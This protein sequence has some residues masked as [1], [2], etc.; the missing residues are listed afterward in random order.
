MIFDVDHPEWLVLLVFAALPMITRGYRLQPYPALGQELADPLSRLLELGLRFA[1]SFAIAALV[2]GLAGL[3]L[4]GGSIER[5]GEGAHIVILVDRSA[6]MDNSFAG[7]PPSGEEE[8]KSA[9]ARRL[10]SAFVETRQHDHFGIAAFSTSPIHVLPLTAEKDAVLAAI[11][12]ID[13]PGLAFTDV[14]RGLAMAVGMHNADT[15]PAPRAILLVSDGA[16]VIDRKVQDQLRKA[17][18]RQP[19]NLYWL[20]LRTQGSKGI[21]YQP[22]PDEV[23]SPERL[24]E[25]HLHK[26]FQTLGVPYRAFQAENPQAIADA[27]REI[28]KLE[29]RLIRYTEEIQQTDLSALAYLLASVALLALVAAKMLEAPALVADRSSV[30]ALH[31]SEGRQS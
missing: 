31:W 14:G 23:D 27:I 18:A 28:D 10:L 17:L 7:R 19:V 8:S 26:L 12:A 25:R 13:R 30:R 4:E 21:F 20:F 29:R 2:L 9:T 22:K 11:E 6:S 16:A 3:H 1:A 15:T 24:P 5:T